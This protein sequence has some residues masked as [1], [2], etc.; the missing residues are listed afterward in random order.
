MPLV[1]D[2]SVPQHVTVRLKARAVSLSALVLT[3]V[4]QR[5]RDG[6]LEWFIAEYEGKEK[7]KVTN[8]G[9]GNFDE[10]KVCNFLSHET[11]SLFERRACEVDVPL[12]ASLAEDRISFAFLRMISGDQVYSAE[13]L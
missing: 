12:Q 7:I 4:L 11:G 1:I 2:D 8:S 6:S 10:F 13:V 9:S 3:P 5:V